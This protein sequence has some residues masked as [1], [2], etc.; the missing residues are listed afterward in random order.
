M[1]VT[2]LFAGELAT[3][4]LKQLIKICRRSC[5]CKS[6]AQQLKHD[7]EDL[8]PIIQEV[9]YTGVEL[10]QRRQTQLDRFSETLRSGLDLTH[11]VLASPRWN[12]YKNLQLARKMEKLERSVSR[13]MNGSLQA[14]VLADVH[15]LRFDMAEGFD[16]V[17]ARI[18]RIGGEEMLGELALKSSCSRRSVEFGGERELGL[19]VGPMGVGRKKVR[20]LIVGRA[21]LAVL[22]IRG[23]GGSGKTTLAREIAKD[24]QLLGCFKDGI[25]FGHFNDRIFFVTVSQSPNVEQL[26]QQLWSQITGNQFIGS[27]GLIPQWKTQFDWGMNSR[28]LIILDDVWSLSVLDQLIF[29]RP[30]CKTLVVSRFK[31]PTIYDSSYELELLRA[32]EALSL[33]CHAAF[34]Q[35]SIPLAA[36]EKL[37]GQIVE[38]CKGLPLALKVIGAS[39][40]G[41]PQMFWTSALNRLSR[42]EPICESH[43]MKLLKRMAISVDY[44]PEKVKECFL[45]LASFPEDKKIPLDVL[46]NIWVE[47]H[48]LHEEEAFA[49]LVELS[50]KNLITLV[51]DARGADA[52]SSYFE[53]AA[54]QHDVLRDLALSLS[55]D[56]SVNQRRRLVMPRR[57]EA[58]PKEWKRNMDQPFH[59][60]IVSIYTG[61]MKESDWFNMDFPKAEVLILN[62]SSAVYYLPQFIQKMPKLRALI[63]INNSNTNTQLQNAAVFASLGNLRSLWLEKVIAPQLSKTITPLHNLQK[64]SLVLCDVR[65]SLNDS[66]ME[67]RLKLPRLSELTIDHCVNVVELPSSICN[68]ASLKSLTVS[69]CHDLLEL[70]AELGRLKSLRALRLYACPALKELPQSICGLEKLEYIDISQCINL[71]RL[72]EDIG[73][74]FKLER[75]DMRECP[76][77][78]SLPPSVVSLAHLRRIICDE[79]A[80]WLWKEVKKLIAALKV[81]VAEESFDLDWLAE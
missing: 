24:E 77:I 73:K 9:K 16:R 23:I 8:L 22:G 49:I 44:L 40:R 58:L 66:S 65:N 61:D 13:F 17:N 78:R 53:I 25:K 46:V 26:Q 70:S 67:L 76:Q 19:V 55:N 7:I 4:L 81:Q 1:A 69:N 2:D 30:G 15:H 28:A 11:E 5:L 6:T 42:S 64:I 37:V 79:E 41:Q 62:F 39:L 38:K 59:A 27:N 51:K 68:I 10:P 47:I 74:L 43:E 48:D 50:D 18:G 52:Y 71:S 33:F 14:H 20:E 12:V 56:G 57:E 36:N 35:K 29:R 60:Q 31:F 72:P 54:T 21:D 3:E 63:L 75:I 34:G 45:D 80:A 32:E